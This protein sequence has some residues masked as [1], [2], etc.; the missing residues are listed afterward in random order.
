MQFNVFLFQVFLF[1]QFYGTKANDNRRTLLHL[2]V[3]IVEQKHSN[4]LD[5][6]QDFHSFLDTASKSNKKKIN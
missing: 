6:D 2:I 3:Q 4:L 1:F 5:F